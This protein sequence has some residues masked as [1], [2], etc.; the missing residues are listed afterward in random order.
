MINVKP[1]RQVC[2]LIDTLS[3]AVSEINVVRNM[4]LTSTE[5][6]LLARHMGKVLSI[7]K[8]YKKILPRHHESTT[9]STIFDKGE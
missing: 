6:D 9:L 4:N 1:S 5:V 3:R 8:E 7:K 2:N